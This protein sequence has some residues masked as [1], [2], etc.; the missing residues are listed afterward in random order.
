[1]G[2]AKIYLSG[3]GPF[4]G[5]THNPTQVI[6][7]TIKEHLSSKQTEYQIDQVNLF[8][9]S[10]G[11]VDESFPSFAQPSTADCTIDKIVYVHLGVS[12][13]QKDFRL[14]KYAYNIT[15]F[16][17]PDE[18]GCQPVSTQISPLLPPSLC[19]TLPLENIQTQLSQSFPVSISSD[20]G[21]FLCN[22]LYFKSLL[23]A[24][25]QNDTICTQSFH[26]LFV[27]VPP[28]DVIP[29]EKQME[30]VCELLNTITKCVL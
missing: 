15:D 20:P 24:N 13:E 3:F 23:N 2:K 12:S 28:F 14:E 25:T 11:G 16:R 22:Y 30:F 5:V 18:R 29:F 19:T 6:V 17:V 21:R 10:I 9:V 26:S 7:T 27:H 1:M 8:E 4:H